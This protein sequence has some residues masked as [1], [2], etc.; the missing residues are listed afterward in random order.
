MDSE[1]VDFEKE[2]SAANRFLDLE[3]SI[4]GDGDWIEREVIGVRTDFDPGN[5]AHRFLT[6]VEYM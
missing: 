4:G 1:K 3:S 6:V 2:E 5:I